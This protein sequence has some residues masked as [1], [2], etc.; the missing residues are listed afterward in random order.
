MKNSTV[1][2]YYA[3]QSEKN[4]LVERQIERLQH[5]PIR[6]CDGENERVSLRPIKAVKPG[7]Y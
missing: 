7:W 5:D 1:N 4:T 2:K 6:L 3:Q